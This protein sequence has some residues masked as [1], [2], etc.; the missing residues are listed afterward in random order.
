MNY[1]GWVGAAIIAA[2]VTANCYSLP[3]DGK[4]EFVVHVPRMTCHAEGRFGRCIAD[5]VGKLRVRWYLHTEPMYESEGLEFQF[6]APLKDTAIEM[7]VTDI[8]GDVSRTCIIVKRI[9]DKA[10]FR[11]CQPGE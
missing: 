6:E 9:N 11:V 2:V 3:V 1:S 8:Y 10:T 4:T 5:D 7:A